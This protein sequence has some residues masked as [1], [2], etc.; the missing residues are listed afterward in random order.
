MMLETVAVSIVGVKALYLLTLDCLGG[1]LPSAGDG[2]GMHHKRFIGVY[3]W[4]LDLF[5]DEGRGMMYAIV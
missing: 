2:N 1:T 3:S 4:S 5:R